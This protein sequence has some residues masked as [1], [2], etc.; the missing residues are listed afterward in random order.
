[1]DN[2]GRKAGSSKPSASA[3][4]PPAKKVARP[5]GLYQ[6]PTGTYSSKISKITWED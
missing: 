2:P 6:P 1:M 5:T 3:Y 4:V